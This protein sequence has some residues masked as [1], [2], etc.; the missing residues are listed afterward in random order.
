M[1]ILIMVAIATLSLSANAICPRP[2]LSTNELI[3]TFAEK[4]GLSC[5]PPY[6]NTYKYLAPALPVAHL[7]IFECT[8]SIVKPEQQ[9]SPLFAVL[10]DYATNNSD[11]STVIV[12]IFNL[13]ELST[14]TYCPG[15]KGKAIYDIV[16]K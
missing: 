8:T 6:T 9:T 2:G 10:S 13:S 12:R 15:L 1:K 5:N 4:H 16:V 3:R 14:G 7:E 11:F